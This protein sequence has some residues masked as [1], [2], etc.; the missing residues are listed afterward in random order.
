[1]YKEKREDLR[2][3]YKQILKSIPSD[4][5]VYLDESG[6]DI[7]MIDKNMSGIEKEK[8]YMII[9][10]V[11]ERTNKRITVISAYSND[12]KQLISHMYF[13]GNTDAN[14]FNIWLEKMLTSKLKTRSSNHNG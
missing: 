14:V 6:F 5:L 3:E 1:M 11:I 9:K 10:V 2:E 8:D 4:N 13:D 12:T 7:N